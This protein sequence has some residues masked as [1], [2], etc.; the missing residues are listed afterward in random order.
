[1]RIQRIC[2]LFLLVSAAH[3]LADEQKVVELY[4][5]WRADPMVDAI[6][7]IDEETP[8]LLQLEI[9]GEQPIPGIRPKD[10]HDC[11]VSSME[12]RRLT[13]FSDTRGYR[14]ETMNAV[15]QIYGRIFNY[16]MI[17]ELTRRGM[18]P[19]DE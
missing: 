9:F 13:G 2:L 5:P 12:V 14:A 8:Y 18:S 15:L 4:D 6:V 17:R 19:C 1:M 3:G 11:W 10:K 7:M 16:Y